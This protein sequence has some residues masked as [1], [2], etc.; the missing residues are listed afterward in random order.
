MLLKQFPDLELISMSG[1]VCADKKPAAINWIEG[2]GR[3][4]ACEVILKKS[5]IEKT[6]KTTASRMAAV[7]RDK[8]LVGSA[9]AG[10]M[11]GFNA[12][13]ANIVAAIF[14]AT[15]NDIAQVVC[16]QP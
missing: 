16:I 2:R 1:N 7:N 3:S 13:A 5:V 9:V 11:G 15:G 14:L 12:H 6:L 8:N 10:S 4:V